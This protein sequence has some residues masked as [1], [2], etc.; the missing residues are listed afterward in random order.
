MYELDNTPLKRGFNPMPPGTNENVLLT[1]VAYEPLGIDGTGD[2]VL[3]FEFEDESGRRF[4]HNEWEIV[5]DRVNHDAKEWYKDYRELLE[6]T[7]TA[8]TERIKHILS[9]YMP[10]K[11][12]NVKGGTWAE[13]S[14]AVINNLDDNFKNKPVR[15]KLILNNKDYT[16]FPKR[17]INDFIQPMSEPNTITYNPKYERIEPKATVDTQEL[18]SMFGSTEPAAP[19]ETRSEDEGL[20]F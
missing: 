5:P 1:R 8:C 17:A 6:S 18:D 2:K 19:I 20:V 12:I 15:I 3:K 13:F 16:R 9:C 4:N 14:E 11:D 10:L 7:L